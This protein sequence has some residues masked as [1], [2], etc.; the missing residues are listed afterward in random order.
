M[1]EELGKYRL[2][3]EENF[4]KLL[5]RENKVLINKKVV[6]RYEIRKG[7]DIPGIISWLRISRILLSKDGSA[8]GIMLTFTDEEHKRKTVTVPITGE[9]K[10]RVVAMFREVSDFTFSVVK[11]EQEK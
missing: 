1:I 6:F 11:E 2:E 5:P 9:K 3:V 8:R 10:I 4:F 7:L